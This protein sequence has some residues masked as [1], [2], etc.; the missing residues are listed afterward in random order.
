MTA[1]GMLKSRPARSLLILV[2][3]VAPHGGLHDHVEAQARA[4]KASGWSVTIACPPGEW[5]DKMGSSYHVL[6][7]DF[8]RT[9]EAG[10]K[11]L[12]VGGFDMVHTHPYRSRK[13]ALRVARELAVPLLGTYHNPRL[14]QLDAHKDS[15]SAVVA[16]SDSIRRSL[17]KDAG[18][19]P[20]K[21]FVIPNGVN[22]RVFRPRRKPIN[23]NKTVFIITRLDKDKKLI[24]DIVE[25]TFQILKNSP[26]RWPE[27]DWE[28][29]G[30]GTEYRRFNAIAGSVN[31]ALGRQAIR[32]RG[33]LDPASIAIQAARSSLVIAP[34]R[35]ALEGMASGVPT[36]A[37]GS[38]GYVGLIDSELALAGLDENFGSLETGLENYTPGR[39][40][41][42]IDTALSGSNSG[43]LSHLGRAIVAGRDQKLVD[44][45]YQRLWEL[46]YAM[47]GVGS[48][49][50]QGRG[51]S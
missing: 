3:F 1:L 23:L 36:I 15:F 38:R 35:S 11:I 44:G 42:D 10:N 18:I 21:V 6:A 4:A 12:A 29:A 22:T 27:I 31:D 37:L 33:W 13:V 34:G 26:H 16:V 45:Q 20:S 39:M 14:D 49:N 50:A 30:D 28:L 9:S 19:P 41:R 8:D 43:H 48:E 2:A 7:L 40:A 24:T 51:D 46:V 5:A 47:H 32:L 17:I 25:E